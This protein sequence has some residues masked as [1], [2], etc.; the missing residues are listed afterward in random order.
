M[1]Q[2]RRCR[3]ASAIDH[4]I[5]VACGLFALALLAGGSLAGD[6]RAEDTA[7]NS[8][9]LV[10]LDFTGEIADLIKLIASKTN[11]NF[12]YDDRVRGRVTVVSPTPI[13]MDQAYRKIRDNAHEFQ[14]NLF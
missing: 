12:I 9:E 10:N 11:R 13:S 2:R 8:G 3:D 1:S 6:V 14:C 7:A 5:A 4:R